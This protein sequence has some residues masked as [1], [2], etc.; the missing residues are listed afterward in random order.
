[1]NKKDKKQLKRLMELE[2]YNN[3]LIKELWGEVFDA[4]EL[5]RIIADKDSIT[6]IVEAIKKNRDEGR[7]TDEQIKQRCAQININIFKE[8]PDN[9]KVDLNKHLFLSDKDTYGFEDVVVRFHIMGEKCPEFICLNA[10]HEVDTAF[11]LGGEQRKAYIVA[12][13]VNGVTTCAELLSFSM[14]AILADKEV[15]YG[16]LVNYDWL[17]AKVQSTVLTGYNLNTLKNFILS[18]WFQQLVV[19]TE[20]EDDRNGEEKD[21]PKYICS[22]E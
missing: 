22:T 4:S 11:F 9:C 3:H 20:E 15:D 6:K 10:Y 8:V 14:V 5:D 17:T 7:V 16:I 12:R 2:D 19:C 21:S 13:D 1:M 18:E